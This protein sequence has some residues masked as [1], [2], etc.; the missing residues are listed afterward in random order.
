MKDEKEQKEIQEKKRD[1]Y[2]SMRS[3]LSNLYKPV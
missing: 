2:P 1:N 3:N